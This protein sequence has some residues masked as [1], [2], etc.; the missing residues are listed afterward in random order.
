MTVADLNNVRMPGFAAKRR[1]KI[2]M[3]K[4]KKKKGSDK[5]RSNVEQ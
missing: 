3:T 5:V 1:K 4:K 2:M